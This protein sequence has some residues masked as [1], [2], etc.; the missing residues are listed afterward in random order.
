MRV[1]DVMTHDVVTVPPGSSARDA[2]ALLAAKGFTMLPVV[3]GGGRLVG[4]VTEVDALRGRL[5]LDPRTLVRGEPARHDP[6]PARTVEGVMSPPDAVVTPE[7]D[8]AVLARR[9]VDADARSAAVVS[10][11]RL[12]GVV[13]RRDLLRVISREDRDLAA[14]VRRRLGLYAGR[15]RWTVSVTDGRVSIVDAMDDPEDRHIVSVLVGAVPG[16]VDVAFPESRH[17]VTGHD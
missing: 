14:E 1:R 15:H 8:L 12:V 10:A 3:D 13:T 2:G 5:S 17:A 7:V 6:A 11:G 4:V 16:V 9:M